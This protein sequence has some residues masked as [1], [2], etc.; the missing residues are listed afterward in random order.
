MSG[1]SYH[2]LHPIIDLTLTFTEAI[3]FQHLILLTYYNVFDRSLYK[4]FLDSGYN[5]LY[6]LDLGHS[7]AIVLLIGGV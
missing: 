5:L 7:L 1:G 2:F 6:R 3:L 4:Y